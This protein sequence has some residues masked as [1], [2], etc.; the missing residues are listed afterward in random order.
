MSS[1]DR[2]EAILAVEGEMA[3]IVRATRAFLLEN[4]ARFS[5]ELPP[6]GFWVLRHIVKNAPVAPGAIVAHIGM[7][8]SVVSRHLRL[9]KD[10]G[11]VT[12]VPDP[13]DGRA[14]LYEPTAATLQRM[15]DIRHEVQSAYAGVLDDWSDDD[16]RRFVQLLGAFNDS[17]ESR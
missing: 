7:D 3:R 2:T 15:A 6:S 10:L 9:L 5:P 12:S 17:L 13:A 14:S 8:K 1:E 11:F 4:A 16:V